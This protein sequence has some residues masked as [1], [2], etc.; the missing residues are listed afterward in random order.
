MTSFYKELYRLKMS[1]VSS[2]LL[3]YT[4]SS[5]LT[6][7]FLFFFNEIFTL[8]P[9]CLGNLHFLSTCILR[10]QIAVIKKFLLVK[11]SAIYWGKYAKDL[12]STSENGL[13]S[14]FPIE[15]WE[16]M[17]AFLTRGCT[18]VRGAGPNTHEQSREEFATRSPGEYSGLLSWCHCSRKNF[19]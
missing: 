8:F 18:V 19:T 2:L 1:S 16:K 9:C 10:W 3:H 5:V 15:H 4:K 11:D 17:P 6:R 14:P 12:P 7:L 13:L